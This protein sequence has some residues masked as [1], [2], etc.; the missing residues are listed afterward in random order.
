MTSVQK[1]DDDQP[2]SD[3]NLDDVFRGSEQAEKEVEASPTK[4]SEQKSEPE[5]EDDKEDAETP[6]AKD[7]EEKLVPVAALKDER[8]KRQELEAKIS[9][10]EEVKLV[11]KPA[12]PDILEDQEGA[13]R[14]T[15]SAVAEI[16]LKERIN[17]SREMM[18]STKE[19]Y[20]AMEN[21]FVDMAKENPSLVIE[22]NKNPNPAKFAYQK[23]KEHAEYSEFQKVKETDEYKEFLEMKKSGKLEKPIEDTPAQKRNKS[24]L[25]MPNLN[26]ATAVASNSIRKMDVPTLDE[27]FAE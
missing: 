24:V 6:T 14:H 17:L 7:T 3:D 11:E 9:K 12:R 15:E 10:Y 19:D 25:S 13:F 26:K 18:L 22:M 2:L 27:M 16:I 23:A 8:R 4:I 21:V 1:E 20:E 5:G